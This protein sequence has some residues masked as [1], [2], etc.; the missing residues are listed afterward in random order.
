MYI[1]GEFTKYD[2]GDQNAEIYNGSKD[3]PSYDLSKVTA[4]VVL[5]YGLNDALAAEEVS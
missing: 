1:P 4:P 3:P 5:F 2:Y